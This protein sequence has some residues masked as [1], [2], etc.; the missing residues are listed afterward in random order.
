MSAD[1]KEIT[2]VSVVWQMGHRRDRPCAEGD[3]SCWDVECDKVSFE[4]IYLALI[5][6]PSH[7]LVVA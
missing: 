7:D 6:R 3:Q 1:W 2:E 5:L 4:G